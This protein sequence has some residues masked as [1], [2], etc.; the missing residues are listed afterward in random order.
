MQILGV[1]IAVVALL[2]VAVNVAMMLLS[3]KAWF[4]CPGWIMLKGTLSEKRSAS[5]WGGAQVRLTGAVMLF[6]VGYMV[7]HVLTRR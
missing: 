6:G 4:R 1:S 3:P 2:V 5:G 7:Y